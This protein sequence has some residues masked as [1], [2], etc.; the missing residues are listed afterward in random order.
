VKLAETEAERLG[1]QRL[2]YRVFVEEM[3]AAV[4]PAERAA[5]REW[6]AFDP[7]FDHLILYDRAPG[8]DDPLDRVVGVYRL[9]RGEAAAAGPG[10]YGAAEY[11]L[12]PLVAT[13]RAL[14]E[15]GRSCVAAEHRGGPAMHLLWQGLADYVLARRI[16]IL[17]GVA[18]FPGTDPA[19]YA[20]A[21]AHLHHAHLAPPELRVRA[22][23]PHRLA[24][25]LMAPEAI[26]APRALQAIPPLI[27]AYLRLG[28][29]VGEGAWIDRAFNT[30]DVC[31]IMDTTRMVQRYRS[32]YARGR[33][34][35]S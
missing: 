31:L 12:A 8:I 9:M 2:R 32:F 24:M 13:G 20:E 21:L 29:C 16:E 18:S 5:R 7:Y 33:E 35:R 6:D 10:F 30:I 27:K 17:F 23:E 26:D 11:D 22:R 28:G 14:V 34:A 1:A 19:P 3:G 15:L 25:D 4:S